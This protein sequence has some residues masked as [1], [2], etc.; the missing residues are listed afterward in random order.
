LKKRNERGIKNMK[1]KDENGV[2]REGLETAG[3]QPGS[4]PT[5]PVLDEP[6]RFSVVFLEDLVSTWSQTY[7]KPV[8]F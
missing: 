5:P 6:W 8:S 3:V 2:S 1:R 7:S 4:N